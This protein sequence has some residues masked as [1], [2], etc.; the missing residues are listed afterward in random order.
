MTNQPSTNNTADTAS[1]DSS[2]RTL[3]PL[4][5]AP[6]ATSLTATPVEDPATAYK[7]LLS[8][9][10]VG[11][12]TF[13]N[14]VV[15]GSMH[16]GLE[17]SIEDVPKLAAFYAARAEG[18][19]AAMVTGGY[20]PVMEGNLTPYGTPFNTPDIAAAHREITDAVHA[21]GAKI[22]LQLL[23]AGRYGYHPMAQSA[24]ASQ[25][26][27][28]PFP[29]REMTA[30]EVEKLIDAYATSAALAADAGYDGVQVM[31]SEGYLINQFLAERTNQRT[32]EWGGSVENRQ[33]F[34]V[35][36]IKAIRAKVPED[37]V[38]DYRISVLE[39]VEGGQSQEEILQLA[40]KIEEAG[41]DMLSSGV[42]WHEAQI[43]TI[44]T[45][46]PRGAFAWATQKVR[47]HVDIPVVAS[48]RIN[49]PEVA[50]A[51]LVGSWN[52]GD[53]QPAGA[54]QADLVSM[55]RPL[56]ADPEFVNRAARGLNTDINHCIACNQACLD[57]T[58][59]NQR[60]TC[61]V[62]PRAAYETELELLPAQGSKKVAVIGGGV[63]GL[64][65]AE[66]L[67]L[68]G[69]DVTVFEAADTLGGQF[70]LAMRVPGKEE[71]VQALYAVVNRLEGLK[72]NISTGK[73]VTP[74][75][76]HEDFEEIVVATGVRPRIPEF[77]GVAEGLEGKI[78]GVT[79]ATYA[80]LISGE[81]TPGEY[82]AV[83]GAGGIGYDVAEFLLED[84]QGTPQTLNS[85]NSQWGVVEAS[86]VHGNLSTP[87]PER[88]QRRVVMLQRKP[89]RMGR[90]LG[91]T[92]GWVHRATVAMGGTEQIVGVTYEKIDSEGLHI[93][94]P[95]EDPQVT[96][97]KIKQVKSGTFEG[98]TLDRAEKQELLEQI[99][100]ETKEN[101]EQRVINVDTVVLCTGQESIRPEGAEQEGASNVHIIGGADVAAELDAKRA[102]RQ[103]VELAARI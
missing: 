101:R 21:G 15:M 40:K 25:S 24:S 90:S 79:V 11:K 20:P 65:A 44:V 87:N 27:I 72:V 12:T 98:R 7:T 18:G 75:E 1:A 84:R 31:G 94:V 100:R 76:L 69:H 49:T 13:R 88:P 41:A 34:P 9:I 5:T 67:A 55:A 89:T 37:F 4:S 23:H 70:N 82:V 32:D 30:E 28:S 52:G 102:I 93:T 36:I 81:K 80:E 16:T 66:A 10:Q 53:G 77:P 33:R 58:F 39:L 2:V 83:I 51:I 56:L 61:L 8:P 50:E 14:R 46:V 74:R 103:A 68:R 62:N 54:P 19:V 43:P 47:D 35:E 91:K 97:K 96:L 99:E 17:D 3:L 73:A 6:G 57:H 86:D 95:V 59:G 92:T 26:P 38:I 42:G 78:D 85:W 22:L 71:F 60:A 29:A 45:S 48:N 64:F 63:A